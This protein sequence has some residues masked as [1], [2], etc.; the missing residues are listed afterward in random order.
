MSFTKILLTIFFIVIVSTN[1]EAIGEDKMSC[2]AKCILA[3]AL[4]KTPGCFDDCMKQCQQH[5]SFEEL[6]V[7]PN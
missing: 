6:N 4:S 1:V 5:I 3:C 2:K 7:A